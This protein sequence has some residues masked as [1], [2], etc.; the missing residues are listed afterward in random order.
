[1][2]QRAAPP[3]ALADDVFVFL[4]HLMRSTQG[5]VFDL[6]GELDLTL[7]QLRVLYVLAP[8]EDA[9]ALGGLASAV[10]LSIAATGRAVDAL[11][12]SGYVSRAEDAA[13][14]RIKRHALTAEG[15]RAMERLAEAR[16]AGVRRFVATLDDADRERLAAALEPVL[17]RL[18]PA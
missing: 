15:R 9:P 13:D 11:V 14:R 12:R 18:G 17:E 7:S 3:D 4:R 5:D 8:A 6:A 2:A 16:R 10:G 1:M